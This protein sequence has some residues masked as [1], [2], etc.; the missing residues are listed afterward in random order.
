M[1]GYLSAPVRPAVRPFQTA[2]PQRHRQLAPQ[3][4]S[5]SLGSD[6]ASGM[7]DLAKLVSSDGS[8]KKT[9]FDGLASQLG[10]PV[11]RRERTLAAAQTE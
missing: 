7:L 2:A 3:R 10:E 1:L 8:G 11:W 9:P 5:A 6:A 4:C